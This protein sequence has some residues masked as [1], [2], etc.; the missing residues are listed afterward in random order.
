[1]A[2][3]LQTNATAALSVDASAEVLAGMVKRQEPFFFIR[4]GDG[5]LECLAG[6]TGQTCDKEVYSPALGAAL[7]SAWRA[8]VRGPN[9]YIGDWLSASFDLISQ[10]SRYAEQYAELIGDATPRFLHFESL[11]IMRESAA[12]V[13]FYRTVAEDTRKKLYMGPKE[14]SGAAR[15]LGAEHLITPMQDLFSQVGLL[16]KLLIASDFEILLYGA[17][18]AGN[19]PAVRCWKRY[20]ER[21]YIN[22]GSAFDVLFHRRTRRQQLTQE[23]A[24]YLFRELL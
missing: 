6:K 3:L 7:L 23:R 9:T 22:V 20:P 2:S 4:Y 16:E 18:M 8:V 11:L 14:C 17:G 12:L 13:N 24:R 19:I 10:H 1:M 21:T 15:M 5:A